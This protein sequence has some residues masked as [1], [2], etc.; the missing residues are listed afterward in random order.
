[1]NTYVNG[2]YLRHN[3]ILVCGVIQK[4]FISYFPHIVISPFFGESRRKSALSTN[5][6]RKIL[7]LLHNTIPMSQKQA[8]GLRTQR[9][10]QVINVYQKQNCSPRM[11]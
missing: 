11:I 3:F 1:M 5:D 6:K 7:K 9:I 4:Y 2:F 8:S 10:E